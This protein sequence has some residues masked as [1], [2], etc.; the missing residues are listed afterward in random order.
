MFR[1]ILSDLRRK[2]AW[3]D[4]EPTPKALV[5]MCLSDGTTAQMIYRAMRFCQT[6]RLRPLAAF[7]YRLNAGISQVVIGRDADIGPGLVILHSCGI[8]IN[9]R[10]RAGRN[11][12]LEN[13]VTIGA[14]KNESPTLGDN[15]FIGTG[16]KVLGPV[17]IGSDVKIGANAVVTRDLP[18]GAT[19]V[20]VPARVVR[21]YGERVTSPRLP[22]KYRLLV[23]SRKDRSRTAPPEAAV[24]EPPHGAA[25]LDPLGTLIPTERTTEWTEERP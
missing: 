10:V 25:V 13:G 22:A 4:L 19:A 23:M 12:V 11:L 18:D 6:R 24:A 20:G 7:L 5:R 9:S 2:A 8:V 1:T 16:A 14:E 3:Y 17:L 15:V 21:I